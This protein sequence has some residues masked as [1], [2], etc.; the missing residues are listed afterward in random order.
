MK[1]Q[2]SRRFISSSTH[3]PGRGAA[4]EGDAAGGGRLG[5]GQGG[6]QRVVSVHTVVQPVLPPG[7]GGA[8]SGA[9]VPGSAV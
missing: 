7:V 1:L 4:A 2:T 8:A 5:Q 6:Q 9:G 3:V